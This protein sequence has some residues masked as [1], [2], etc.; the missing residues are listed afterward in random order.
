M[1][2]KWAEISLAMAFAMRVLPHPGG[3]ER[4]TLD[5][6]LR[7]EAKI[8]YLRA[9]ELNPSH[10]SSMMDLSDVLVLLGSYDEGLFGPRGALVHGS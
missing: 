7:R 1:E 9:L 3:H 10:G 5:W 8:A 2:M 6:R 4:A